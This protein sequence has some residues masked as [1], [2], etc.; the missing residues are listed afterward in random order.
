MRHEAIFN[1]DS[2]ELKK[3]LF[4]RICREKMRSGKINTKRKPP[5]L[6]L[7]YEIERY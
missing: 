7:T 1:N 4:S 6:V 5:F 3:F 2:E